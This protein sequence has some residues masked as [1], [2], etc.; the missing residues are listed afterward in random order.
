MPTRPQRPSAGTSNAYRD[1]K[2][3]RL[4]A[5]KDPY[6]PANLFRLNHNIRPSQP[7]EPVLV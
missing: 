7:A 3:A 6:D 1:A 5:L 2:Y 4:A